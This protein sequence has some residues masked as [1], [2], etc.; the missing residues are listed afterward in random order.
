VGKSR[1]RVGA[2]RL[3]GRSW[4]E[5]KRRADE[6]GAFGS[7]GPRYGPSSAP[8]ADGPGLDEAQAALSLLPL[9]SC[10]RPYTRS[11]SSAAHE[12]STCR[13]SAALLVLYSRASPSRVALSDSDCHATNSLSTSESPL[14][15][16]TTKFRTKLSARPNA[17]LPLAGVREAVAWGR[18]CSQGQGLQLLL[19]RHSRRPTS[20][21]EP[22]FAAAQS[23]TAIVRYSAD[24]ALAISQSPSYSISPLFLCALRSPTSKSSSSQLVRS[25]NCPSRC[26]TRARHQ[27]RRRRMSKVSQRS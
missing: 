6:D 27:L 5:R 2:G 11:V 14:P 25:P 4:Q 13:P 10:P 18:G 24:P 15:S 8:S 26:C 3:R 21:T 23:S 7:A 16:A 9:S 22:H 20:F 12:I 17:S 19:V 1:G